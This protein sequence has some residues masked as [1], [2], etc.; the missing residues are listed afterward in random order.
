MLTAGAASANVTCTREVSYHIYDNELLAVNLNSSDFRPQVISSIDNDFCNATHSTIIVDSSN[1]AFFNPNYKQ[2][3]YDFK[4]TTVATAKHRLPYPYKA[5]IEHQYIKLTK[6]HNPGSFAISTFDNGKH[7][8]ASSTSENNSILEEFAIFVAQLV[9]YF[10]EG[11]SNNLVTQRDWDF[12]EVNLANHSLWWSCYVDP[13]KA[14]E[15][16]IEDVTETRYSTTR[17]P[18]ILQ[19]SVG[20][21]YIL[22]SLPDPEQMSTSEIE[23][24]DVELIPVNELKKRVHGLEISPARGVEMPIKTGGPL[25]VAHNVTVEFI[26]ID[27]NVMPIM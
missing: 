7:I 13:D 21:I 17:Q 9:N 4:A 10:D 12:D 14:V 22:P 5:G 18:M 16:K 20:G 3:Q 2:W 15:F 1:T 26:P 19:Q 27:P 23:M 24:Y 11:G 25:Y 8:E 6:T